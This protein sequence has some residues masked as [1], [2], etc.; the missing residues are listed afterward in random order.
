MVRNSP[1]KNVKG[2]T[3]IQVEQ[4]TRDHKPDEQDEYKRIIEKNGWVDAFKDQNGEPMGPMWVWLKDE[5]IPGLA[6]SW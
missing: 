3:S 6:M 1:Q 2:V 5:E 4:L